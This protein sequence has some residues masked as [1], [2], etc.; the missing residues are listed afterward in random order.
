MMMTF[1]GSVFRGS[2]SVV[3]KKYNISDFTFRAPHNPSSFTKIKYIWG[4][5]LDISLFTEHDVTIAIFFFLF[6]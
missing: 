4:Y 6:N 3:Q 5:S 2:S 1:C